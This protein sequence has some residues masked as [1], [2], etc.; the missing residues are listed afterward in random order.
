MSLRD[1]DPGGAGPF[2]RVAARRTDSLLAE[3]GEAFRKR[4]WAHRHEPRGVEMTAWQRAAALIDGRV[5]G[6]GPPVPLRQFHDPGESQA[7]GT[8]RTAGP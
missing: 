8:S 3:L 6:G 5:Y 2:V 4:T 1:R 7:Y